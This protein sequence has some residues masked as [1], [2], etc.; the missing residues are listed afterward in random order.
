MVSR[1]WI[2]GV[3]MGAVVAG[4]GWEVEATVPPGADTADTLIAAIATAAD[5]DT[6]I[7]ETG[8]YSRSDTATNPFLVDK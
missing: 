4:H 3:V 2:G 6:L 8:T 7:L 5:G 1:L